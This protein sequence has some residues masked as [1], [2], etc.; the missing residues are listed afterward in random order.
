MF[1]AQKPQCSRRGLETDP[2]KLQAC[3]VSPC[4]PLSEG[5]VF[6]FFRR[7]FGICED[8]NIKKMDNQT[9]CEKT[10]VNGLTGA[11]W[12][13]RFPSIVEEALLLYIPLGRG[14]LL[15]FEAFGE[16]RSSHDINT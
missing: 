7:K 11:S 1:S 14:I 5:C 13:P 8:P 3:S 2:E 9:P 16:A 15:P 4:R 6:C 10:F 12:Y